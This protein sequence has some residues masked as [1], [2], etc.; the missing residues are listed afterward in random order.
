MLREEV[1]AACREG[2]FAVRPV[3]TVD[4]AFGA[5]DRHRSE[6]NE[7]GDFQK[8]DGEH[9]VLNQLVQFAVIAES[10]AKLVRIR[11]LRVTQTL[12]GISIPSRGDGKAD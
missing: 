1:V 9:P 3:R 6:A 8:G 11:T 7:A 10:F 2:T 12:A 4:E 5:V